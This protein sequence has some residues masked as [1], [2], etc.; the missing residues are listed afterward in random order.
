MDIS[1]VKILN[2]QTIKLFQDIKDLFPMLKHKVFM[3]K[4]IHQLLSSVFLIKNLLKM[5]WDWQQMD[6]ILINKPFLIILK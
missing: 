1:I 4:D 6:L 3:E 2:Y 5:F